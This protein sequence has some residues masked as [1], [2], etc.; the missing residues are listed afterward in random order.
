MEIVC[1]HCNTRHYLSDERIPLETKIG[2]CKQCSAPITVLGKKATVSI[3]P[4]PIQSTP[5]EPEATKNCDFCGE[6]ILAIAKKC[7]YCGSM[8]DGSHAAN[9]QAGVKLPEDI[10]PPRTDNVVDNTVALSFGILF[11]VIAIICMFLAITMVTTVETVSGEQIYNNG[12]MSLQSNLLIGAGFSFISGI[13]IIFYAKFSALNNV[14]KKSIH[15]EIIKKEAFVD[16]TLSYKVDCIIKEII[17]AIMAVFK[18][19]IDAIMTVFKEIVVAVYVP[20][21]SNIAKIKQKISGYIMATLLWSKKIKIKTITGFKNEE[22][23]GIL[24]K[25]GL[26]IGIF[27]LPYVFSFFTLK[28]GYSK[29]LRVIAFSWLFIVLCIWWLQSNIQTKC[30][31]LEKAI[32]TNPYTAI[33][34]EALNMYKEEGC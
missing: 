31:E 10:T 8:L 18:E 2:K 11:I 3:E 4:T 30:E 28:E 21:I 29:R 17:D 5:P 32:N 15:T 6:K 1:E 23:L 12:L 25:V 13:L 26:F 20:N 16:N 27:F 34:L 22:L 19:I 14:K 7:R 33:Y 9:S 24:Q